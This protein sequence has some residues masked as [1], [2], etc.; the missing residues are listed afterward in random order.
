MRVLM[1]LTD[2]DIPDVLA[3]IGLGYIIA[4]GVEPAI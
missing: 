2:A 3:R 4:S 1:V